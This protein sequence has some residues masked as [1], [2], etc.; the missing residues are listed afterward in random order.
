M[1]TKTTSGAIELLLKAA[2]AQGPLATR[3]DRNE[4]IEVKFDE[5]QVWFS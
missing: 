4:P 5:G 3:L 1:I 2:G